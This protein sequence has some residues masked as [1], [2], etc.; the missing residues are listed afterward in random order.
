MLQPV[1]V[2]VREDLTPGAILRPRVA[3]S[4]VRPRIMGSRRICT[5]NNSSEVS[6]SGTKVIDR[7]DGPMSALPLSRESSQGSSTISRAAAVL[8]DKGLTAVPYLAHSAGGKKGSNSSEVNTRHSQPPREEGEQGKEK[9][10]CATRFAARA[11]T[12]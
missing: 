11:H 10:T 9:K 8:Q 3:I 5:G 1:V 7:S 12:Q 2:V 4:A 6:G